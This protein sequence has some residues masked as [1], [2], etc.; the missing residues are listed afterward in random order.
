MASETRVRP[1]SIR[2]ALAGAGAAAALACGPGAVPSVDTP[3]GGTRM[4]AD[5]L[6]FIYAQ[7]RARPERHE[8]LNAE[9]LVAFQYALLNQPGARGYQ[10]RFS[11]AR[12]RLLAGQTREAIADL[13]A[14]GRLA[15]PLLA[16]G[17]PHDKPFFDLLGIA[18]LRLAAQENCNLHANS[19]VCIPGQV[20]HE[21][22]EGAR[23]AISLYEALLR[24]FPDD[25][26]SRW[27][28]NV[29]HMAV[30]EY[31]RGVPERFLIPDL[32]RRRN[33]FPRFT[34]IARDAG[35][36][37]TGR[38]GGLCIADFD[39]DGLLDLFTTAWGLND[40][41]HLLMA[42]GE[43][44]YQ[45]RATAAGLTGIV[46]GPNCAPADYDNDGQTDIFVMRGGWL[47]DAGRLPNSL[48]RNRGD[49]TFEDVTFAAG[50]GTLHPT[51]TAAWADFDLD[52]WL[53]LFVGNESGVG[54]GWSSHLSE[55]F[56]NNGDGTFTD[57][58]GTVGLTLDAFVKGS[59]WGDV[60][61]DGLPDLFVSIMGRPNR[62]FLN[63]GTRFEDVSTTAGTQAP[64]MS[65]PT[66]FWDYDNDGWED[67][68]VLSFDNRAPLHVAVAREY[69]GLAP[70]PIGEPPSVQ[71]SHLYRNRG[72]GTFEDVTR[73]SG[74][75]DRVIH[76]MGSNLGDV[77]NDGWLDFYA[78]TGNPDLRSI[79]PN[80]MFR[81]VAGRAFQDITVEGGFGHLQKGHGTA[82][83]DL[84]RDG[85]EDIFMV[86]GGA[87]TADV[88]TSVLFE[89]PG[90]PGRNWI[91]LELEGRTANRS[92]IGARVEIVAEDAEGARRRIRRTIGAGSSFGASALQLHVGLGTAVRVPVV[93]ITWPDSARTTTVYENLEAK[94]SH[95][96]IEGALPTR[97][98]RA[99]VPFRRPE[100]SAALH[101]T[102]DPR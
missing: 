77:D 70:M 5:T 55:L 100:R 38:A 13:E 101:R 9:R 42:D 93:R 39:R 46:G 96:L 97:L 83:V 85:D 47:G 64:D 31:P 73:R 86:L 36:D 54:L 30:G 58:A 8:Y 94:R 66:W 84:D 17:V 18:H 11:L 88:A 33:A 78:G 71:H 81:S 50:L 19:S 95:L 99:P 3:R 49:G 48:L 14:L 79:I 92:A 89:N 53:D 26:G 56:R 22:E 43:G 10:A 12:E 90:W 37:V 68:L 82:F 15:M 72:D 75:A 62:L 1:L 59:A 24:E 4:M 74:L 44:G 91:T 65:F 80:R 52:G 69:L 29:A 6:A 23:A 7:A 61:N 60:N 21:Q 2:R 40:P 45:E 87:Y 67:L 27:L 32:T 98:D 63:R 51:Q 28:L 34:D 76:A 25:H 20:R 35:V 102:F 41:V 57:V 16:A